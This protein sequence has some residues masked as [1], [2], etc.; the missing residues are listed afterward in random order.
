MYIENGIA[1]AGEKTVGVK[2]CGVRA[3]SDH[4]LWLRFNTGE[5]KVFD[6]KPLLNK[7]AYEILKDIENFKSLYIDYGV[8][9]WNDGETD[10]SP[11][12]L[13]ENS[14]TVKETA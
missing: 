4:T 9:V 13:Y 10:I 14:E 5:S 12:Y 1:Y 2:I 11:E 8:L 6:F 7:K 3:F